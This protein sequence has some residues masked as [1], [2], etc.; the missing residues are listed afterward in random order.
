MGG[1]KANEWSSSSELKE[2]SRGIFNN[3][4]CMFSFINMITVNI[5]IMCL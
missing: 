3:T 4:K 5:Y 1:F 2:N